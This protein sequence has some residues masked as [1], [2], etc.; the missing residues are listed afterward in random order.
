MADRL[1]SMY[2]LFDMEP[3]NEFSKDG[4]PKGSE[5]DGGGEN[6]PEVYGFSVQ[7]AVAPR[8]ILPTRAPGHRYFLEGTG[9]RRSSVSSSSP[10]GGCSSMHVW[11]DYKDH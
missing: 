6:A 1:S 7:E 8:E 5:G 3:V 2:L 4:P 11:V 9:D 10:F